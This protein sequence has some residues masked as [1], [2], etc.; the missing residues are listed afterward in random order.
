MKIFQKMYPW[1]AVAL[2]F[3]AFSLRAQVQQPQI[4]FSDIESGPSTGGQNGNG[5]FVTIW[6]KGFGAAQ[7]TSSVTVGGVTA[8]AYPV[9]S[10]GKISFQLG[11]SSVTGNIVVNVAGSGASN[12]LAFTVRAGKIFFVSTTGSD[13]NAGS[14]SAPWKTIVKAKNT[15]AAGDIAYMENGVAQTTEDNFTAYLSMDNNG[16]SNSGTATA[17]KALVAYPGATVTVGVAGG[18]HYGIRTPNISAHEDYWVISQLH[19]IGGTQAMDLGG[20]GWRII[21]NDMQCPGADDEVGCFEMSEGTQTRFYGNEIHNAGINPTSSKFYHAV[22]FSTDS[23]HIDV[24]WNHIHDNFTCRALQFHSSPLCSPTC[25]AGDTTGF[26]QF[27][28]HVHDNLIHGDNCNGI[29]FATVDP[30][31]GTVEAYNNVIYNVGRMDPLQL[32][33]AFSCIY[34]AGITNN[35]AEGTG[36]V[37][38][39]NN[40]LSDCAANNS[41]NAQGSRGAF[42]VGGGPATLLMNLRNNVAYQNAGEIYVDGA[43]AQIK[44]DHNL[45]F[46]VGAAPTQTT[47]NLSVDPLFVNRAGADFHL[48][49]T[50]PA[51]DAGVTMLPSNSFTANLGTTPKDKD[52]VARPQGTAFDMG[53]YEFFTGSSTPPPTENPPT[54]VRVTVR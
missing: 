6:G 32:G 27:D 7:G 25:G 35:G 44:G 2:L 48:T 10:D 13:T 40:T 30:S 53:A 18:L 26:N 17:P 1:I 20:V 21:G 51:K 9:W 16:A 31:K 45:W 28:L 5:A 47:N 24:G 11:A 4:F 49:S 46:G 22:Y 29:N 3:S 43:T 50:S 23:N 12:G 36:T 34:V 38:I 37:Q 54:N 42:G 8:A 19:I 39:F 33:A 14:F 15:I 41:S 52:G